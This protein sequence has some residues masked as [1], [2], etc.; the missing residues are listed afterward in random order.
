MPKYNHTEEMH[1]LDAPNE[2]VPKI[3]ELINPKSVVDIGCGLGTFLKVFKKEG[4]IRILGLDGSWCKKDLLF[5][6]ISQGE[7]LEVNMEEQISINQTFDL[8]V[9]LEVAEHIS[10]SRAAGFVKDLTQLSDYILFSAAIPKQG[11]DHHYNE[12]WLEYWISHFEKSGFKVYDVLKPFF[13]NNQKIFWWYKQ[14]MVLFIRDG[15]ESSEILNLP[16]NSLKNIIHPELFLTV[17]DISEKNAIK[18]YFRGFVKS[19]GYKLG[20][21]KV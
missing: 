12:Q 6:N 17:V 1:N 13:W 7:F 10:E 11:G 9:C 8:A 19:V 4:A 20:L 3:M 16:Q 15:K 14:N 18:R 2:I 5:K 21:V